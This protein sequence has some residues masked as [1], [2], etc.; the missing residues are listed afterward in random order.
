[1]GDERPLRGPPVARATL[2]GA[3]QH[4]V[5][6]RDGNA[7]LAAAA[8]PRER[9]VRWR[10]R[11]IL[12][13]IA[14]AVA[15]LVALW[16]A[17]EVSTILLTAFLG[18]LF[19]LA[20]TAAVDWF[21]RFR[22]PRGLAAAAVV[23]AVYGSLVGVGFWIAPTLREQGQ[24]LR[25]RLPE[26]VQRIEG[27]LAAQG[28]GLVDLVEAPTA[29]AG[30]SSETTTT[31]RR[32]APPVDQQGTSSTA[33]PAAQEEPRSIRDAFGEQLGSITRYVG[34]LLSRTATAVGGLLLITFVAVYLAIEPRT[35]RN[36]LLLL[37][38]EPARERAR[39]VMGATVSVL[40][41]WLVTQL[42]GMI[43][44]GAV[45]T[46]LLLAMGVKAAVALGI[47]AGL[48]EFVP[49]VGPIIAAVP[50]I[51]MGFLDSPEK[52][53]WV[54]GA[55]L[56]IQQ[57][58]SNLLMPLLMRE[59]LALPPILTLLAQG[60]MALLFG[61]LGVIVAVP[62]LA[63]VVVPV[64]MLYVRD[65]IGEAIAIPGHDPADDAD[66]DD[67]GEPE[68]AAPDGRATSG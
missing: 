1:M 29:A 50:A 5:A 23:L 13:F 27:W 45:T 31:P 3:T 26:A 58:E 55:Y 68:P 38:P 42:I 7:D 28:T 56:V 39:E 52:A 48:L 64:K 4:D 34:P 6:S 60:A 21:A 30:T 40:R 46:G 33:R 37:V 16:V 53:L 41:R 14:L 24:E 15:F 8:E 12:R 66:A 10:S 43:V 59:G 35:Y 47:I 61:F 32:D 9:I 11:D 57:L 20:L 17:W 18:V 63:A 62:L 54:A 67:D 49:F 25:H 19:G 44:I 36:G 2:A 65:V 51:A 22:V